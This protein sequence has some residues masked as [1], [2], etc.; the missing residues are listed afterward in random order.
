[1]LTILK[2]QTANFTVTVTRDG[3]AISVASA[4]DI[5]AQLFTARGLDSLSDPVVCTDSDPGADWENGVVAVSFPD[6]ETEDLTPG[7]AMLVLHGSFGVKRFRVMVESVDDPTH[8]QLFVRDLIIE[9]VRADQLMQTTRRFSGVKAPLSDDYIWSKIVAA[10]ADMA[11]ELRVPLVP[12]KFFPSTPAP[13]V[14][15]DLDMPWSIDPGYDYQQDM[16]FPDKWG[17]LKLN[18]R[19]LISVE[20]VSFDFPT[21]GDSFFEMPIEWLRSYDKYGHVQFVPSTP[22]LFSTAGTF[23]M[24][25]LTGYNLVPMMVHITYVAGLPDAAKNYP[26]LLDAIKKAAV[27]YA[28]E[29]WFPAQSGSISADGLS[30]SI[31]VDTAKYRDTIDAVVNGEPGT[32]GGLMAA[33]H[34]IRSIVM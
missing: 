13:E 19:P 2:G 33:I 4:S 17:M 11:R 9:E 21:M 7:M 32:N 22:A 34:G 3:N 30:Q 15:A 23:V 16:F 29:D 10:E 14:I 26:E 12:T 1:M 6:T 31:S 8:S 25:A 28:I 24:R 5:M 27:L 18:N 20:K